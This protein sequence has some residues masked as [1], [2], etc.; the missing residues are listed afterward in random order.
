MNTDVFLVFRF[1]SESNFEYIKTSKNIFSKNIRVFLVNQSTASPRY[2]PA[3][4]TSTQFHL[5]TKMIN[6]ENEI[7]WLGQFKL[8]WPIVTGILIGGSCNRLCLF[9]QNS[10]KYAISTFQLF[11]MYAIF[12]SPVN[13]LGCACI[14]YVQN[15]R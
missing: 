5:S 7:F 6:N 8:R 12:R 10:T 3:K 15:I 1:F 4:I 9:V 2:L 14:T 13:N 11:I